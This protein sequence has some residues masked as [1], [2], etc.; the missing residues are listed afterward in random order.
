MSKPIKRDKLIERLCAELAKSQQDNGVLLERLAWY[1][2]CVDDQVTA[3]EIV[4]P[5][6]RKAVSGKRHLHVVESKS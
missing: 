5:G 1:K 3:L 2:S 4:S 6:Y